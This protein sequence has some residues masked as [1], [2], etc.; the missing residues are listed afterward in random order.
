[1]SSGTGVIHKICDVFA[2][3]LVLSDLYRKYVIHGRV[4]VSYF[5]KDDYRG[6]FR[7]VLT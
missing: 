7:S 5:L 1:M 3:V 2:K 4:R 6:L